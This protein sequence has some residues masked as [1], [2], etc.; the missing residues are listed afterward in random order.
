MSRLLNEAIGE[1]F[2][3]ACTYTQNSLVMVPT[4]SGPNPSSH[5]EVFGRCYLWAK[6]V[7]TRGKSKAMMTTAESP[8]AQASRIFLSSPAKDK[9][10]LCSL[11]AQ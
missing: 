10:M 3:Q 7:E 6:K 4:A 5:V 11:I 1:I 2:A 8:L 9:S